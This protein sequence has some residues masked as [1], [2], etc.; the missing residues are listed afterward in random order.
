MSQAGNLYEGDRLPQAGTTFFSSTPLAETSG[1][2][3]QTNRASRSVFRYPD[4]LRGVVVT[5]IEDDSGFRRGR[6]I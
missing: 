3:P 1:H 6:L 2:V 5:A 4:V